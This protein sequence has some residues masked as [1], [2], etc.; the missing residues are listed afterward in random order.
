MGIRK[1][2]L[3][4]FQS[5][6]ITL[7]TPEWKSWM[8]HVTSFSRV[9]PWDPAAHLF[10][11]WFHGLL[12]KS[13]GHT[14]TELSPKWFGVIWDFMGARWCECDPAGPPG[15]PAL[16]PR[17]L[18]APGF[19]VG[20]EPVHRDAVMLPLTVSY[21]RVCHVHCVLSFL[22]IGEG[23]WASYITF[24]M[25]EDCLPSVWPEFIHIRFDPSAF[26]PRLLFTR[27]SLWFYLFK[28]CESNV[29]CCSVVDHWCSSGAEMW[30]GC[31]V[32]TKKS[33]ERPR[34]WEDERLSAWRE[35]RPKS[36]RL[37]LGLMRVGCVAWMQILVCVSTCEIFNNAP[38]WYCAQNTQSFLWHRF[39]RTSDPNEEITIN[40]ICIKN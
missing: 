2:S 23:R 32:N 14:N 20:G 37:F 33:L 29:F 7:I 24:V 36:V 4:C 31:L 35:M 30:T 25:Q 39:C 19:N 18:L 21:K 6:L 10:Q 27:L 9:G 26:S 11:L 38:Y 5:L 28:L 13:R 40:T 16:R 8:V 22:W 3:V 34:L 17:A 12:W 1:R 15:C